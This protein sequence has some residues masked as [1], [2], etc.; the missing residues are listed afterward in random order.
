MSHVNLATV[1]IKRNSEHDAPPECVCAWDEWSIEGNWEG[2]R[3]A[4]AEALKSIGE[5]LWQYRTFNLRVPLDP[6]EESF[7]EY[8]SVTAEAVTELDDPRA[9]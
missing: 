8:R 9:L 2:W 5:D 7:Q 3:N 6:I 4:V 1:W